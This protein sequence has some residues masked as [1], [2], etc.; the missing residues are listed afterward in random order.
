MSLTIRDDIKKLCR[1]LLAAFFVIFLIVNPPEISAEEQSVHYQPS[2]T[3]K[4]RW[5]PPELRNPTTILLPDSAT[6]TNLDT[7]GGISDPNRDY[8]IQLPDNIK[9]GNTTII[10]GRNVHIIGGQITIPP[11]P[12]PYD[13]DRRALYIKN[14]N[15][16]VHIE[17]LHITSTNDEYFDAISISSPHSI[18]Q[19]QNI[20]ID[21]VRGEQNGYHGDLLQPFG[22]VKE[23]RVY[24][25]TGTTNYQGFF[26]PVEKSKIE[27]AYLERIDIQYTNEPPAEGGYLLFLDMFCEQIYDIVLE[28]FYILPAENRFGLQTVEERVGKSIMP[29]VDVSSCPATFVPGSGYWYWPDLPQI[30][31]REGEN[32]FIIPGRPTKGSFVQTGSGGIGIAGLGYSSPGYNSDVAQKPLPTPLTSPN[33]PINRN[34]F[35]DVP[36]SNTFYTPIMNLARDGIVS[37]YEDGSFKPEQPV[38]RGQM[39]K[40]I[41]NAYKI[42]TD[43]GCGDFPDVSKSNTFYTEITTLKCKGVIRGFDNGSFRPDLYVTRGQAMKFVMEGLRS[44]H[45]DNAYLLYSGSDQLFIDVPTDYAFYEYIMAAEQEGIVSGYGDGYF[46]PDAVS[47]RGAMSKMVDNARVK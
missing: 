15:G 44:F 27:K 33:T 2:D 10:G 25:L 14:N 12:G 20:R 7:W 34:D 39:S 41:K 45:E 47:T 37:G 21:G 26:L 18:V 46:H 17:G 32:G 8:I 22:G 6:T 3:D 28:D 5:S 42:K 23:L 13:L 29:D 36:V 11:D 35:I 4:L 43:T 31:N 1:L 19:I 38:T 9:S 24:K 16:T 30:Q 40:F